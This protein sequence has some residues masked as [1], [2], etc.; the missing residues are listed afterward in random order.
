[1]KDAAF[2]DGCQ[3]GSLIGVKLLHW[4]GATCIAQDEFIFRVESTGALTAEV[5][6]QHAIEIIIEKINSLSAAVREIQSQEEWPWKMAGFQ[7][8]ASFLSSY[9]YTS[10]RSHA[11]HTELMDLRT[12]FGTTRT[13]CIG[14]SASNIR[15]QTFSSPPDRLSWCMYGKALINIFLHTGWVDRDCNYSDYFCN[16]SNIHGI[17][18]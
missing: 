11:L 15:M 12:V 13:F 1:M 16:F 5:I 7:Y 6:V 8:T 17:P 4:W 9:L 18:G 14:L 2:I 10:R 3:S